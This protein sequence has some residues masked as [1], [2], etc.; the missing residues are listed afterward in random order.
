MSKVR[1]SHA[2]LSYTPPA[3]CPVEEIKVSLW[4]ETIYIYTDESWIS[5]MEGW[6][7]EGETSILSL[8][9]NEVDVEM[10]GTWKRP[11]EEQVQE[12]YEALMQLPPAKEWIED[13]WSPYFPPEGEEDE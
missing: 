10:E 9:G 2:I 3:K 5:P 6:L 13:R 1:F 7:E 12:F 4:P 8:C 11:I